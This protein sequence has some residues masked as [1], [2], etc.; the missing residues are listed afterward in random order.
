MKEVEIKGIVENALFY[1]PPGSNRMYYQRY[2]IETD[3]LVY[4]TEI[5]NQSHYDISVSIFRMFN[6]PDAPGVIKKY[7]KETLDNFKKRLEEED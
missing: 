3:E 4:E 7:S 2:D 5:V 6:N 1:Y